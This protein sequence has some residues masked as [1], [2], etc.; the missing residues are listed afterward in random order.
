MRLTKTCTACPRGCR[1]DIVK[2]GEAV[3]V[4]G[5]RCRRGVDYGRQEAEE[6]RRILTTTVRTAERGAPRLP[7]KTG[8]SIPLREFPRAMARINA[9]QLKAPLHC[10]DVVEHNFLGL[11]VDLLATEELPVSGCARVPPKTRRGKAM[12]PKTRRDE[13]KRHG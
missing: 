10:G 2:E 8:G 11:G 1:L 4:S 12:P 13:A 6:P 5:H 9:I 7:V 3:S